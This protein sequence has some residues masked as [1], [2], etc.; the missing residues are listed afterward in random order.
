[1]KKYQNFRDNLRTRGDYDPSCVSEGLTDTAG[2]GGAGGSIRGVYN[3][4]NGTDLNG[5]AD[6]SRNPHHLRS[7]EVL[8]TLVKGINLELGGPHSHTV[9]P[10]QK[11][12]QK[13]GLSGLSLE[14]TPTT[15]LEP[16]Q[17]RFTLVQNNVFETGVDFGEVFAE[18][19]D[20]GPMELVLDVVELE[21]GLGIK[22]DI[23]TS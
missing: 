19:E 15:N 18:S 17:H 6:G 3:T 13:L 7:P 5:I 8:R 21:N 12:V 14:R 9:V 2:G 23:V 22:A 16:G 10:I 20:L 1:M 11:M 4:H